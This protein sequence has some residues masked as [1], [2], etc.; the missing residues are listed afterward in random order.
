MKLADDGEILLR[1]EPVF[2]GYYGRPEA[3]AEAL[4]DGWLK[5]GDV[6]MLENDGQ[7]RIV[8][9]KKDLI[10]TAGGKNIAPSEIE[11]K[12]KFSPFIKEAVI[13]G[14]RRKYLTALIQLETDNVADWAQDH[15]I[16]YTT[17]KSLA[18]NDSVRDLIQGEVDNVNKDLARVET[19]KKFT[20]LNKELDQDDEEL[21]ATMKVRRSI[22]E[23]KFKDLIERMY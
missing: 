18:E 17:Y 19:I 11:N 8:D 7:V 14:D 4:D 5:T 13:I 1:G 6:G 21:T 20:I 16:V 22:I 23:K 2:A 10:I 12:L 15:G 3:T 9:R